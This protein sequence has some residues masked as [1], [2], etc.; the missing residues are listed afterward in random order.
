MGLMLMAEDEFDSVRTEL[1]QA[2][3][4]NSNLAEAHNLLGQVQMNLDGPEAAIESFGT[5]LDLD[6]LS[7]DSAPALVLAYYASG[8]R[9]DALKVL[10]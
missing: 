1:Q 6:P 4:L 3:Q 10:Q 8:R 7:L 5:S 2:I 9:A